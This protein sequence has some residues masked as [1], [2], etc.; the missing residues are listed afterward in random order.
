MNQDLVRSIQRDFPKIFLACHVDHVRRDTTAHG[1]SSHEAAILSHL[2]Q[3]LPVGVGE[4][5]T[6][7]G[8]A[9]STLSGALRRLEGLGL[10]QRRP[11]DSDR[12]RVGL[13]LTESGEAARAEASVLDTARL[14]ALLEGLTP[15]QRREAARGIA[16]LAQAAVALMHGAPP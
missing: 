14:E 9:A 4:L 5:A 15:D 10:V 13:T 3:G 11:Q 16:L 6:H 2:H 7:L 1:I 8:V 12:R